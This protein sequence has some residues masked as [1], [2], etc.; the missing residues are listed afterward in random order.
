MWKLSASQSASIPRPSGRSASPTIRRWVLTRIW[1][2]S[3]NRREQEVARLEVR[4]H[5][6]GRG[7]PAGQRLEPVQA[8]ELRPDRRLAPGVD[9]RRGGRVGGQRGGSLVAAREGLILLAI[10]LGTP[11]GSVGGSAEPPPGRCSGPGASRDSTGDRSCSRE[12]GAKSPDTDPARPVEGPGA[13]IGFYPFDGNSARVLTGTGHSTPTGQAGVYRCQ[14][15][16]AT[17]QAED[18]PDPHFF[19]GR[20]RRT[21]GREPVA[22]ARTAPGLARGRPGR[23]T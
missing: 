4:G 18:R 21:A 9:E 6:P 3:A 11:P 13:S 7:Q 5:D 1:P 8:V 15:A 16:D 12:A 19:P 23:Y 10:S 17:A 14:S 22:A 20:A 2:F